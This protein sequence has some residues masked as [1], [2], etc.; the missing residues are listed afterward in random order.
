MDEYNSGMDHEVKVY[1]R[2]IMKSFSAGLFWMMLVVTAG[3]FFKLGYLD[4]GW[5]WYNAVFYGLLLASFILLL[6][7]YFRVWKK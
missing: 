1:F 7:F 2:K 5:H 4:R 6:R 3:L